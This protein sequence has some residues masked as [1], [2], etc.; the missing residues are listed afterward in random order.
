MRV[1]VSNQ[2]GRWI[3]DEATE[4]VSY[5]GKFGFDVCSFER[6]GEILAE[7]LDQ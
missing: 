1:E 5:I 6:F 4:T 2:T 7:A 3:F